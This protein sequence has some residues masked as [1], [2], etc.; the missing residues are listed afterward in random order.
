ML[1]ALVLM[2]AGYCHLVVA[3][4]VGEEPGGAGADEPD[5]GFV[6]PVANTTVREDAGSVHKHNVVAEPV[7]PVSEMVE[8]DQ[9]LLRTEQSTQWNVAEEYLSQ[10]PEDFRLRHIA[11]SE[12]NIQMAGAC[13]D[14]AADRRGWGCAVGCACRWMEQ[15]YIKS[16]TVERP[17]NVSGSRVVNIGMCDKS[18]PILAAESV[19]IFVLLF[20]IVTY[21]RRRFEC[22]ESLDATKD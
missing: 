16:Y 13:A 18:I 12:L 6:M 20:V 21:L 17:V 8:M 4:R 3:V 14:N 11:G 5:A 7:R 22:T 1:A 19:A 9:E 10:F 2:A 15:C